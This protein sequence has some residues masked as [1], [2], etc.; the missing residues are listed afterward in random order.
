MRISV[1]VFIISFLAISCSIHNETA[2]E[3]TMQVVQPDTVVTP[4][5]TDLIIAHRNKTDLDMKNGDHSPIEPDSLATFKG[6]NYFPISEY[7]NVRASYTIIDTGTVFNLPTTTDRVIPMKKHGL[8]IFTHQN[9][10]IKLFVYTYIE[11]PDEDLFV[12]FL[13]ATN[14]DLTYGG[15][16]YVEVKYPD[17]D[18]VW[19]DFNKAYN[20]YCAYNHH[21]SCPI[22]PLENTLVI[23]I[24]AGEKVLYNY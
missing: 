13:D 19:I 20:P 18:S 24:D 8:I 12:P 9:K 6:L 10:E 15:G 5:Y 2:D 22:P 14:G 11:H 1:F 7:W 21:Y 17:H 16:R 4:S 23:T 3:K